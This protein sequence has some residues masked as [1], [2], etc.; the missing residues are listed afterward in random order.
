M[1]VSGTPTDY[2]LDSHCDSRMLKGNES[3]Q[4]FYVT[5]LM[6]YHPEGPNL[7]QA[8]HKLRFLK[9]HILY[10][11]TLA[12]P[13]VSVIWCSTVIWYPRYQITSDLVPTRFTVIL[14]SQ[15]THAPERISLVIYFPLE[16]MFSLYF[17]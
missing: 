11:F 5:A 12:L 8:F 9:L 16:V 1:G 2:Y 4:G 10:K 15:E 6:I 13:V 3:F 17:I 14:V 7:I